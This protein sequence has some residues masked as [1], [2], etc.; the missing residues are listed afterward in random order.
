MN[1]Q[2]N[3]FAENAQGMGLTS[4]QSRVIILNAN[5]DFSLSKDEPKVKL[6]IPAQ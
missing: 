4:I 5:L 1:E 3:K 6:L 2:F